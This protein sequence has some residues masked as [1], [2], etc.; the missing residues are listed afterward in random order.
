M[1]GIV[2]TLL[3]LRDRG[4]MAATAPSALRRAAAA[5]PDYEAGREQLDL[6]RQVGHGDAV[7]EPGACA[8]AE[9]PHRLVHGGECR[10]G[11][12]AG[13]DVVESGHGEIIGH[14]DATSGERLEYADG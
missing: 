11:Q 10:I 12:A 13:K 8:L 2:Q 3:T 7:E 1:N 5:A 9:Q 6:L 14:A 4:G